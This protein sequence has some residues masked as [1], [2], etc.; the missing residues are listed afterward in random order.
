[1]IENDQQENLS[2]YIRAVWRRGQTLHVTAGMLALCRWGIPLFLVGM[3]IDWLIDLPAPGRVVILVTLLSVSIYRAW[4]CGWRHAG[5]FNAAHMALRIEEHFGGLESLLVTAVQFRGTERHPGTSESLRNLTCLRAEEVVVSLRPEQAVAYRQLRLPAMAALIM[6]MF[7]GSFAVVNGRFLAAGAARVFAPWLAVRYPTRTRLSLGNGN[8]IVR[9]GGSVRL[10]ARVSGVIP[11]E[12][13]LALRTS[14]GKSRKHTLVITDGGCEYTIKSVFRGF[15][16]RIIAGDA[17]TDWC[18]VEVIASPRIERA[19]VTLEF[20]QYT[21]RPTQTVEALTLT[22]PEGTGVKWRLILDRAVSK[23]EVNLAGGKSLPLDVSQDGRTVTMR[24]DA[25]ESRAYSFSWVEREHGFSFTSPRHQLQVMPDQRPHVELTSPSGDLYATLG[26]KLDL[27]FRGRD[28]HGIGESVVAYRVN[29]TEDQK[30]RFETPA[31]REGGEHQIDWDYRSVLPDL[32]IGDS[33][34]FAIELTDRYPGS[35]GPH[36]ARSEARR[37]TFLSKEDYLAYVARQKRRLL[38]RLRG[39]YREERGV[40]DIVRCLDPSDAV[41]VQTCQLEA[42]RQDLMRERLG[43]LTRRMRNLIED[44]AANNIS[45]ETN[46]AMLVRLCSDMQTVADKHVGGA[47]SSL[48]TLAAASGNGASA[49]ATDPGPAVHAVN[50]AARELGCLVLQ[51]GYKDAAEVMARELHATAQTQAS[52]RLETIMPSDV[53]S[54]GIG[55]LSKAQ[56]R[57]AKWL[58]RLAAAT[59][60]EKESTIENAL[61]AFNLSRLVKRLLGTGVEVKMGEAAALIRNGQASDAASLQAQACH[62]LLHAEF[63]LRV[64]SEYEALRN[65]RDL[66]I[67]QANG[68]DILRGEITALTAKEFN[69]R[70]S[71]FVRSQTVLQRNLQLLLMPSV[72]APRP[73]L[74]DAVLPSPPPVDD[75]LAVAEGAM[76]KATVHIQAGDREAAAVQQSSASESFNALAEIVRERIDALTQGARLA[77]LAMNGGKQA[78][79]IEEFQERLLGLLEKTEDAAADRA[80]SVYLT[81]LGQA[82]VDDAEKFRMSFVQSDKSRGASS[83]D[84]LPLP[85]CLGR[86]VDAIAKT[87]PLLKNNQPGLAVS[88]LKAALEV[89]D[90]AGTLI[91]EQTATHSA[92]AGVFGDTQAVLVPSPQLEDIEE[93]Q[94]DMMATTRKAKPTDLPGLVIPQKNLVHAVDA[95]LDSL[96]VLAHKIESGSVMLFAKT[97]MNAAGVALAANDIEEAIDAQSYV[98]DTLRDLRGKIDAATPQYRYVLEVTEFLHEIIPES[99]RI[100]MGLRKLREQMQAK[101]DADALGALAGRQQSLKAEARQFCDQ[102]LKLTGQQRYAGTA[103]QMAEAIGRLKPSDNSPAQTQI[104]QATKALIAEAANLR[105]LMGNLAYLIAPPSSFVAS[106]AEPTPEVKLI[107]GVL[108]L[109]AQQK[110]MYRKTQANMAGQIASLAKE[111][112][113]LEKQCTA[114]VL[115]SQSHPNLVAAKRHISEAAAKLEASLRAEAVASQHEAGE[116]LRYFILEYALKYVDVP[117]PGPPE[118]SAPTEPVESLDDEMMMF[119]PG[120]ITVSYTHL[121]LPTN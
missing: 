68:Q 13:K 10:H 49:H 118:D 43:V 20:P 17:R 55:A 83:Q 77:G 64:G 90:E 23:A 58:I 18:S 65:A 116:V 54:D 59:P 98:A 14:A 34:S 91:E 97:D 115:A 92:F 38:L 7:L 15:E 8:L 102:L 108:T 101:P 104:N 117:P 119:M 72:P 86:V 74:F 87:V 88:G 71:E 82:L 79:K 9:E 37:V 41:F 11:N 5:A 42:V 26:R 16:Y 69:D 39:I 22:V 28:D 30:V 1:M 48:R 21:D 61:V 4:R 96:D 95:V 52:L 32:A 94:R 84:D 100:R 33:V 62:A 60:R 40:H 50:T 12:A 107:L 25:T 36:L 106:S 44:L 93:E 53:S 46:T 120:A 113:R 24:R 73:R 78:T 63:R 75:L 81:K 85:D 121:T 109:A 114:F 45:D 70:R 99:D 29:K 19:E 111:Q 89:L 67:A 76:K 57:L 80:S 47:A 103:S 2:S 6:V 110:D 31:F 3:A 56:S 51:L 66:F 112:R 27:A 35:S 105:T